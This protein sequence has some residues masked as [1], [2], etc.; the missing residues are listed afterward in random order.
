MNKEKVLSVLGH[1]AIVAAGV[2]LAD[3]LKQAMAKAKLS[4]PLMVKEEE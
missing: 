1:I 4:K 3:Q 2:L